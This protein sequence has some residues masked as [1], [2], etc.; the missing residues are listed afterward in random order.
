MKG[1]WKKVC[2]RALSMLLCVS[3]LMPVGQEVTAASVKDS[4]EKIKV[5]D[6]SRIAEDKLPEGDYIYFGTASSC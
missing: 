1:K 2:Q 4:E 3:L 6:S 5:L